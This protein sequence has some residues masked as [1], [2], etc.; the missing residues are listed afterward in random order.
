VLFSGD[1]VTGLIDPNASRSEC[2]AADLARLLGSLIGDDRSAWDAGLASY[3][4]ARPL[5]LN[6]LALVELYDQ[7][8]V[9]LS[10]MTW[11]DWHCLQ[12]REF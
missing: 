7:S 8:A 10:G 11:L 4:A 3:Q 1:D 12:G 6:E 2:V 5:T 9:L